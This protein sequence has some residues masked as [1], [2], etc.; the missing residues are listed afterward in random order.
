MSVDPTFPLFPM[1]CIMGAVM[2]VLTLSTSL[3]RQR[4]N[5]GVTFLCFWLMLELAM[6]SASLIIWSDNGDIKYYAFCDI[7]TRVQMLSSIVK[8][9]ATFLISRRLYLIINLRSMA[10]PSPRERRLDMLF[11]WTLGLIFPVIVAGPLYYIVQQS[12]FRVYE[13]FGCTGTGSGVLGLLLLGVWTVV[14]PLLSVMVYY[15]AVFRSFYRQSRAIN[16][17]LQSNGSIS[18]TNYQRILIIA[19]IDII[20]TL[21]LGIVNFALN[22]LPANTQGFYPGWSYVHTDWEPVSISYAQ[23]RESG[24]ANVAWLYLLPWVSPILAI[25]IF[26]LFGCTLEARATYWRILC[27]VTGWFG[28]T[29]TPRRR[30]SHP[31]LGGPI[32]FREPSHGISVG[33]I[34][35]HPSFINPPLKAQRQR[36]E[37]NELAATAHDEVEKAETTEECA[38]GSIVDDEPGLHAKETGSSAAQSLV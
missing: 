20:L 12:R 33:T 19:S 31:S 1:V 25:A 32:A 23:I 30:G 16:E 4:W 2:M 38:S 24:T 17:F 35:S 7:F 36:E 8:P 22:A 29:P 6:G 26:G 11:E 15:P 28:W 34:G 37:N 27:K 9:V 14:F 13:G 21:P 5:L 10:M 3:V 18:H